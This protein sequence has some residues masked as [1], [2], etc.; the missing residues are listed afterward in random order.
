MHDIDTNNKLKIFVDIIK[1]NR[2]PDE[3]NKNYKSSN[4]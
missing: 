1:T 3:N 4:I 2:I